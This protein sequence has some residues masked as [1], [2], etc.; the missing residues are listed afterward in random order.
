MPVGRFRDR[1]GEG[2]VEVRTADGLETGDFR[3]GCFRDGAHEQVAAGRAPVDA[4]LGRHRRRRK[5]DD[6]GK[7]KQADY[8]VRVSR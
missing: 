8:H 4:G 5:G 6:G 7:R 1:V 3:R 2:L